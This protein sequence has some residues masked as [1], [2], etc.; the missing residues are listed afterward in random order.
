[1]IFGLTRI[2]LELGCCFLMASAFEL[3]VFASM[4]SMF[5]ASEAKSE[6]D[7]ETGMMLSEG[8]TIA[9]LDSELKESIEVGVKTASNDFLLDPTN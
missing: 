9:G 6:L 7:E 5:T 4:S 3:I 1:M 2:G 8:G